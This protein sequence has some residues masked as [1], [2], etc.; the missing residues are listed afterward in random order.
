[1]VKKK[2]GN[3]AKQKTYEAEMKGKNPVNDKFLVLTISKMA[4]K[5]FAASWSDREH[6]A[7]TMKD[8]ENKFVSKI[9]K[10]SVID[11][12]G[13]HDEDKLTSL[14]KAGKGMNWTNGITETNVI[15]KG[16]Q[17]FKAMKK[18]ELPEGTITTGMFA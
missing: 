15:P 4:E 18:V 7:Q 10:F 6:L 1:M 9:L 13:E 12:A 5:A 14:L 2:Y 16:F 11:M 17:Q 8:V 3:P